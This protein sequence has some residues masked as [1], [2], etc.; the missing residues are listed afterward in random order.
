MT[1]KRVLDKLDIIDSRLNDIDKTLA[2]QHVTLEEHTRRST[3]LEEEFKPLKKHTTMVDGA[4][5][6]VALAGIVAAFVESIH[7]IFSWLK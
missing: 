1:L 2:A 7:V 3:M 6:F 5:K 4:V